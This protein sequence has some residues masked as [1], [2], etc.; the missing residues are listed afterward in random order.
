[1]L[2]PRLVN[3]ELLLSHSDEAGDIHLIVSEDRLSVFLA[4]STVDGKKR[5]SVKTIKT[6]LA[7]KGV[8]AKID[9]PLVEQMLGSLREPF[10]ATSYTKIAAGVSPADGENSRLRPLFSA[11]NG[12]VSQ[13]E[14]LAVEIA[15]G[16]GS[17]GVD[18]F[19]AEIPG[20]P[21]ETVEIRLGENVVLDEES[22]KI[23]A[24]RNGFALVAGNA[25]AVSPCFQVKVSEDRYQAT[26]SFDHPQAGFADLARLLA[27]VGIVFGL[28]EKPLKAAFAE[29]LADAL[30]AAQGIKPVEGKDAEIEY[31]FA[32][33]TGW[34]TIDGRHWKIQRQNVLAMFD[35]GEKLILIT[36]AIAGV[37][38]KT[39]FGELAPVRKAHGAAIT[40][41][42]NAVQ[43][44][45][46]GIQVF[47]GKIRGA[48]ILHG[49]VLEV[50]DE[51]VVD[52]D[53]RPDSGEIR[54]GGNVVVKG[55]VVSGD[56]IYSDKDIVVKGA[57]YDAILHAKGNISVESG[58]HGAKAGKVACGGNLT[59]KYLDD[60]FIEVAGDVVIANEI[61]ASHVCCLGV[62]R[63]GNGAI[64]G[65]EI[66][67]LKGIDAKYIGNS[68]YVKTQVIA[69][70][71][72][73]LLSAL[74][75]H[76][77]EKAR[78]NGERVALNEQIQQYKANPKAVALMSAKQREGLKAM[79]L[80]LTDIAK[81]I[82]VVDSI[83]NEVKQREVDAGVREMHVRKALYPG[84]RVEMGAAFHDIREEVGGPVKVAFDGKVTLSRG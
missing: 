59:A 72:Y 7:E 56:A 51:Y 77:E 57:V 80:R 14:E 79:L 4:V 47:S 48:P 42:R 41:G 6:L 21:G 5:H 43:E 36:P 22:G 45:V 28:Q 75:L 30:A 81:Q 70:K 66:V 23:V 60:C 15:P 11:P 16:E 68:S 17:K 69:G 27:S 65:G 26:V 25:V 46:D 8:A 78:L 31:H 44:T 39:V 82:E 64:Y 62:V 74:K 24:A 52:G 73:T 84:V 10:S 54:F 50:V 63:C 71:D 40:A 55:D 58:I 83:F 53:M 18:V 20:K 35:A 12:A 19:G 2:E 37:P 13:G 3:C 33:K 29:G 38:G 61:I 1:M 67:A 49:N 32:R 34:Q 76:D 9:E